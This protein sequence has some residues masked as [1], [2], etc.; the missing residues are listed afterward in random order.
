MLSE[1]IKGLCLIPTSI[2]LHINRLKYK[3]CLVFN[4]L[5]FIVNPSISPRHYIFI[6]THL[7]CPIYTFEFRL[8]GFSLDIRQGVERVVLRLKRLGDFS[9]VE[10]S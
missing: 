1:P 3:E 9:L 6:K 2:N 8:D 5:L 7:L 10:V 4:S